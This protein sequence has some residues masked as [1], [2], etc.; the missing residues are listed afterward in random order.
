MSF[1]DPKGGMVARDTSLWHPFS[2]MALV[3]ESELVIT[4]GEDVW[5]WD[6][7][8]KRYLDG[9]ASLW[10][11][12]VG[13]GREEI[14]DAVAAQ[15]KELEAY[16]IFGDVANRPALALAERLSGLAPMEDA[17]IFLTT[18]GGEAID[19]AAKIARR[20]FAAI[21]Q[22]SRQHLIGRIGGYHGTNGFGTSIGGIESNRV[23]FGALVPHT[24]YVPHDSAEALERE[25]HRL[26]ADNV[27][28][29]FMEP[30]IGAGGVMLP[31]KGYI[32]G[33]REVCD[34]NGVLLVVDSVICGFGRLGTWFG[35]ER[36]DIEPD[37][38]TFAKGVS[39]GYMPVG[40]VVASW[41]VAEPFFT[42]PGHL[43][44]H[45]ATYS[46]HAACAA[47][48]LANLDILEREGLVGRARELE[49]EFEAALRSLEDHPLVTEVRAGTGLMG[50]VDVSSP[51]L[52]P[53]VYAHLREEG[54]LTRAL[55][56]GLAF[57]PPL[58]VR[59]EEIDLIRSAM[60][61]ALDA[62]LDSAAAPAAVAG[63]P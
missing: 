59:S 12:N 37:L 62:T 28:A 63:R 51:A 36:W 44:R 49:G 38:M 50:A 27:A 34:A 41:R 33:V 47:A 56:Q 48:A 3:R 53:T 60:R 35:I 54:V 43:L 19:S 42:Q 39:S 17:K 2:D 9:S 10:Y 21:G 7:D 61:N 20:Y 46:G 32:E 31:P 25:I 55:G 45:G 26:G 18:G 13:H 52:V 40:G 29:F 14:A 58:T 57:S 8:G 1:D 16:S 11:A 15:M 23:G 4:R 24:S 30:I 22:S 6:K 5:L